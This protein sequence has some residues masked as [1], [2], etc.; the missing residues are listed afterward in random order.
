MANAGC[1]NAIWFDWCFIRTLQCLDSSNIG[2]GVQ[3]T[4]PNPLDDKRF[5]YITYTDKCWCQCC[6]T[7]ENEILIYATQWVIKNLTLTN[8][9][10]NERVIVKWTDL[11]GS[12]RAKTVV[13]Y[14]TWSYPSSPTDW[15]LA[16]EETTQN[17][18]QTNWYWVSWL[19]D[20]TTYYFSVFALDWDGTTINV[21]S[22][23]IK[24][25]YKWKPWANTLS[26]F[27]LR[28][29]FVDVKWARTLSPYNVSISW[30]YAVLSQA[31]SRLP[32]S[33][34]ISWTSITAMCW[35]YYQQYNTTW[36]WSSIFVRNWWDYHHLLISWNQ[37]DWIALWRVWYYNKDVSPKFQYSN[38]NLTPWNWYHLVITK[39]WSNE[40]IYVNSNL[41]LDN[42]YWFNNSSY[43]ISIIWNYN[44]SGWQQWAIGKM[45]EVIFETWN[46][47]QADITKY[48]N[49]TKSEFW[50]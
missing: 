40:K 41:V 34:G 38:M 4:A 27:P 47:T 18:Y 45:C 29:D 30:W 11:F 33:S 5:D 39:N 49:K 15:T 26:Y 43:P 31:T 14:K 37:N 35:F 44:S 7:D 16:V 17:Q 22:S 8:D 50:Y 23:S 9:D 13:R 10:T 20:W 2:V 6:L 28:T 19:T 12:N 21:Q 3:Y 32:L 1:I 48:F 36:S 42:N 25:D 46:W 24:P